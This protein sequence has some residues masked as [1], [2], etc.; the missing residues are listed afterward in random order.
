MFL[1]LQAATQ[2]L[3]SRIT[4]INSSYDSDDMEA[5]FAGEVVN[6]AAANV[7]KLNPRI[8]TAHHNITALGYMCLKSPRSTTHPYQG[9]KL[10]T[11]LI[12]SLCLADSVQHQDRLLVT[13]NID[14]DRLPVQ[15]HDQ[16]RVNDTY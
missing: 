11:S 6:D 2:L 3:T 8:W 10:G 7:N 5:N 15:F 9:S 14:S 13:M 1:R 4:H 12:S 16:K